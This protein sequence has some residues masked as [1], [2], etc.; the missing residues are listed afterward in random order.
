MKLILGRVGR[1]GLFLLFLALLDLLYGYSLL[2]API[3]GGGDGEPLLLVLP[4]VAWGW[5]WLGTGAAL[6]VGAFTRRDR[7]YFALASFLMAAW[8]GAWAAAWL[9]HNDDASSRSWATVVIWGAFAGVVLVIS[10]WPEV[11]PLS[12]PAPPGGG[13]PP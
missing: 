5:C 1:R 12:P 6:A 3:S 8:A 13:G 10:T 9:S 7:L 4:G 2:A 11:K